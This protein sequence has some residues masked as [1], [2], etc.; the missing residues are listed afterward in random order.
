ML[1]PIPREFSYF[2]ALCPFRNFQFLLSKQHCLFS[3]SQASLMAQWVKNPPSNT[4][5]TGSIPGSGRSPGGGNGNPLQQ[6]SCLK[7]FHGQRSFAVNSA[8]GHKESDTTERP[9]EQALSHYLS[10]ALLSPCQFF[11]ETY[12]GIVSEYFQTCLCTA[13]YLVY[14]FPRSLTTLGCVTIT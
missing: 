14:T 7:K 4:G 8:Q 6:Y 11:P 3:Q 13:C 12:Q 1:S 10:L 5:D 2:P 9:S